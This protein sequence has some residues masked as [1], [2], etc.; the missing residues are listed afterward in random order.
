MSYFFF[1][2]CNN[3]FT[4]LY[5][6]T[7]I[8]LAHGLSFLSRN[9]LLFLHCSSNP[10]FLL[11]ISRRSIYHQS[12]LVEYYHRYH[13]HHPLLLEDWLDQQYLMVRIFSI[14]RT[15]TQYTPPI[16]ADHPRE[17]SAAYISKTFGWGSTPL[18]PPWYSCS[19]IVS[20]SSVI[21]TIPGY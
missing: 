9:N 3:F 12:T 15:T 20:N 4:S 7:A 11:V 6:Q 5:S 17:R 2:N 13:D 21:Y 14:V 10:A 1:F 16:I 19:V 18:L 8:L